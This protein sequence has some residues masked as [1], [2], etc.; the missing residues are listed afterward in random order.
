MQTTGGDDGEDDLD[1]VAIVAMTIRHGADDAKRYIDAMALGEI[2]EDDVDSDDARIARIE[3]TS[4]DI[5][6][7]IA[8]METLLADMKRPAQPETKLV[9]SNEPRS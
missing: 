2:S 9:P 3:E 1:D 4:A 6:Q 7:R 8:R 5:D